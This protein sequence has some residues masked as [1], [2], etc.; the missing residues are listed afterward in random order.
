MTYQ[1]KRLR[2]RSVTASGAPPSP[3]PRCLRLSWPR[4]KV[5][6][7]RRSHQASR[8][9]VSFEQEKLRMRNFN[10]SVS[11]TNW[12]AKFAQNLI[13]KFAALCTG[14]AV[15]YFFFRPA[16]LKQKSSQLCLSRQSLS[17][18]PELCGDILDQRAVQ[19]AVRIVFHRA[20]RSVS[21]TLTFRSCQYSHKTE[22]VCFSEN[23]KRKNN[24]P[25]VPIFSK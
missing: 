6:D 7:P 14:K 8:R 25:T 13:C 20:L 5:A 1:C 9:V 19:T 17:L 4:S 3:P 15:D 22:L 23:K 11:Q 21:L 24:T 10:V 12:C 16:V 2:A 18:P